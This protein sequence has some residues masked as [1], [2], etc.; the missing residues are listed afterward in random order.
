MGRRVLLGGLLVAA[1]WLTGCDLFGPDG[2]PVVLEL[3]PTRGIVGSQVIVVGEGFGATQ[4]TGAVTFDD[5]P[6]P[7]LSW[8]DRIVTAT[9]PIVA[10]P[11]GEPAAA[12]VTVT[13]D[14][15]TVGRGEFTVVRGILFESERAGGHDIWMLDPDAASL[16][17]L[18]DDPGTEAWPCWSHDGTQ[19][20]FNR[21]A[22]IWIMGADGSNQRA[23]TTGGVPAFYPVWSPDDE[24]IAY[25][26]GEASEVRVVDADGSGT[27]LLT[28][29]FGLHGWTT[30]SP[31]GA[32]IAFH[33]DRNVIPGDLETIGDDPDIFTVNANGTAEQQLTTAPG[34]DWFPEWSPDGSKILFLSDRDGPGEIFSMNPD[35]TGQTNLTSNPAADGWPAWSP[36]GSRIA[37][38]SYRD[39]NA[40]IYV[41]NAD[42]S[43][44]SRLT[45]NAAFDGGPSWSPDGSRIAFESDRDGDFEIYVMN[46]DGSEQ[47]QLTTDAALDGF[48]VWTASRWIP[49]RP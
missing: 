22:A 46:A 25:T 28:T 20:A 4:G 27:T 12:T 34:R 9:V 19:I 40:E 38:Q 29:D 48:P 5:V 18:T 49:I 33:A 8:S 10:T 45:V 42:G 1:L 2:E 26:A 31:D 36:D 37:F 44:L 30:W 47:T 21:G 3:S 32:R 41:M 7:V 23:L 39:G 14:G 13:A 17:R 6:A 35:G 11:N 16:I 15:G 24:K 43:S